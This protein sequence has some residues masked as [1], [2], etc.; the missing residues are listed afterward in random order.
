MTIDFSKNV[1]CIGTQ[2]QLCGKYFG[3]LA[4]RD[5]KSAMDIVTKLKEVGASTACI[6]C[7]RKRGII[8]ITPG[9]DKELM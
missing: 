3:A 8:P 9:A 4:L 5:T 7:I 2:C 6:E 1:V